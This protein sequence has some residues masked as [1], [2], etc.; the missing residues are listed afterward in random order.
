[1]AIAKKL[2]AYL[3][4]H[5]HK[6]Y[7]LVRHPHSASSMETAEVAH[8]PGDCLAKGVVLKDATGYLVVV[9][10]SDFHVELETLNEMTHRE[11][12]MASE[13]ELAELFPDCEVGA[14]PPLGMAYEIET[15]WDT[16]LGDKETVFFEAG[17]HESLVK[18]S[19][20][21]FHELMAPATRGLFSRRI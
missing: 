9:L 2:K 15:L 14:I 7:R 4:T 18:V 10:P 12:H 5:N 13:T 19:G 16:S 21:H 1:M 11:M 3:D 6:N 8:I 17:D 20:R